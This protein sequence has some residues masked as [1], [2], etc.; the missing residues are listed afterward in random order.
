MVTRVSKSLAA[1]LK[2]KVFKHYAFYPGETSLQLGQ[3]PDKEKRREER[4]KRGEKSEILPLC[5][6]KEKCEACVSDG[7]ERMRLRE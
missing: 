3:V 6:W 7:R 1:S 4:E 5:W 2:Q